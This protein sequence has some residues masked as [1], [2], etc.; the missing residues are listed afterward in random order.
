MEI[1]TKKEIRIAKKPSRGKI[2]NTQRRTSS[3]SASTPSGRY[4]NPTDVTMKMESAE[5]SV[6][7]QNG[8]GMNQFTIKATTMATPAR[9]YA[10][11]GAPY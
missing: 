5:V 11:K 6:A 1:N 2:E 7:R 9:R 3:G 4:I 8:L 10:I